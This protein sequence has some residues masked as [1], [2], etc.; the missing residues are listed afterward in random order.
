MGQ[1]DTGTLT[2]DLHLLVTFV[3][4]LLMYATPVIYPNSSI[5]ERFHWI[6]EAQPHDASGRKFSLC[7]PGRRLGPPAGFPL[8][9]WLY[10]VGG[11][12]W[13]GGV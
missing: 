8:Q 6:I 7:L 9:F 12:R 2:N 11:D 5:P 4:Q 13:I 1:I 10:V 3:V